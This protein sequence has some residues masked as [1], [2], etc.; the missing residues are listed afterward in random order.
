MPSACLVEGVHVCCS[1]QPFQQAQ[2]S[3]V[4]NMRRAEPL[5]LSATFSKLV[6]LAFNEHEQDDKQVLARILCV[7]CNVF[8]FP[9]A[10]HQAPENV[11]LAADSCVLCNRG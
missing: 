5:M 11:E 7:V 10:R 3:A 2:S 4:M 9:G 1:G 8:A 6:S